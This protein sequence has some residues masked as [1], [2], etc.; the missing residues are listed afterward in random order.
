MPGR[1]PQPFSHYDRDNLGLSERYQSKSSKYCNTAKA[2]R[3]PTEVL[4]FF[5][6][7]RKF[8]MPLSGKSFRD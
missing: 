6:V 7:L 8:M 5:Y 3:G 4:V 1:V 2:Y